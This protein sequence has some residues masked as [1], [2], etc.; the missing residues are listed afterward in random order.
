MPLTTRTSV[1]VVAVLILVAAFFLFQVHYPPPP[2]PPAPPHSGTFINASIAAQNSHV[3]VYRNVTTGWAAQSKWTPKWLSTHIPVLKDVV[4]LHHSHK[5]VYQE[6]NKPIQP[7][8]NTTNGTETRYMKTTA[9]FSKCKAT[10]EKNHIW[11]S[12]SLSHRPSPSSAVVVE[13][14][15]KPI[16]RFVVNNQLLSVNSWMGCQNVTTSLHRDF[17]HNVFVQLHGRKEFL[18]IDATV[19]L[20]MHPYTAFNY[21]HPLHDDAKHFQRGTTV[22]VKRIVL[23]P[24]DVL[25][26]PPLTYHQ[27]RALDPVSISINVWSKSMEDHAMDHITYQIPLPFEHEW[28]SSIHRVFG[29]LLYLSKVLSKHGGLKQWHTNRWSRLSTANRALDY[30]LHSV[31]VR[32]EQSLQQGAAMSFDEFK[33]QQRSL[34]ILAYMQ[35]TMGHKPMQYQAQLLWN[36]ADEAITFSCRDCPEE[37]SNDELETIIGVFVGMFVLR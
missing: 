2:A 34:K 11:H 10:Q 18:L 23:D 32:F 16:E 22:A 6:P 30:Q 21:L 12:S 7:A 5:Y 19:A 1:N 9:F 28:T 17:S 37:Y 25:Y 29:C 36:F 26:L 4:V 15:V 31:F 27:V 20:P 3:R 14:D 8:S 13:N 24:G 33:F 35:S